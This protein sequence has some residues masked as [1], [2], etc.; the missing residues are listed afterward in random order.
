MILIDNDNDEKNYQCQYVHCY[1]HYYFYCYYNKN[2][3]IFV[4]NGSTLVITRQVTLL[5][6]T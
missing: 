4:I 6:I 1:Y 2:A 3:S 5:V